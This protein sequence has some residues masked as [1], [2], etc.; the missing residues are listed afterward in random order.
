M[1]FI[2]FKVH[3]AGQEIKTTLFYYDTFLVTRDKTTETYEVFFKEH[4][5]YPGLEDTRFIDIFRNVR[6]LLICNRKDLKNEDSKLH[7]DEIARIK[8]L[9]NIKRT[10]QITYPVPN[11]FFMNYIDP[12]HIC[13]DDKCR[14]SLE[15]LNAE[16]W[17][18]IHHFTKKEGDFCKLVQEKH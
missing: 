12:S 14:A 2:S 15:S 3:S 7:Q 6:F 10:E 4:S 18:I 9:H 11:G 17:P 16:Y 8:K 1:T 13:S 5:E